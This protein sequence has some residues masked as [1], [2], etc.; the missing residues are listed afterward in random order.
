VSEPDLEL[1]AAGWLERGCLVACQDPEERMVMRITLVV[2]R[3]MNSSD[4]T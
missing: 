3:S 2:R 1:P 4:L